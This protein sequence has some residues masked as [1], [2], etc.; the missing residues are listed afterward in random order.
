MDIRITGLSGLPEVGR[1]DD[2]AALIRER[3][4]PDADTIVV[5][6]QKIVSKA[7]GAEVDLRGVQ[8][9]ELAR[10]WAE[11]WNK[12]ARLVEV[13]LRQSR[14]IVKMERGVLIA[15]THHGFVA[16]NAGVDQSNVPGDHRVTI[17]PADPDASARRLRA[18][19]GCGAVII[20]DTFGR[21]W[22][23]GLVNVAIG[24][25]GMEAMEDWR[26]RQ[27]YAGKRL[28]GTTIALADEIAAASG[29][30]MRKD[31]G[32]P[33]ALVSGVEWTRGEGSSRTLLRDPA[34]DLFR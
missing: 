4:T 20:S 23:E 19:L 3:A 7:E 30:V 11:C 29:L 16:A 33:V 18:Q 22:R 24:V 28:Q 34:H 26:G 14:R 13:V 6:A 2:L 17:L 5:V 31:A 10:S 15:E 9:S 32:V 8:P 27:D 21:P 12:D 25:S 1:G